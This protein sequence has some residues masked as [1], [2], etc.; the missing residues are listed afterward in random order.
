LDAGKVAYF[1]WSW[2]AA[3]GALLPALEPRLK[4]LIL[5]SGGFSG[6]SPLPEADPVNFASHVTAPVLM[7]NARYDHFFPLET[8]QLPMYRLFAAPDKDK[9]HVVVDSWHNLP[10]YIAIRET[11]PWL[12]RYLGPVK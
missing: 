2:G 1:G 8:S 12:D 6:G 7:I 3:M 9:R 11:L 5:E 10:K 4:V